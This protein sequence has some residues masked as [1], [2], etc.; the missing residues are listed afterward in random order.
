LQIL[1]SCSDAARVSSR[2]KSLAGKKV[3]LPDAPAYPVGR[4]AGVPIMNHPAHS[5]VSPAPAALPQPA[6]SLRRY[7]A[8]VC[9][10]MVVTNLGQLVSLGDKPLKFLLKD[11]IQL[12]PTA[13]A[14]W[15]SLALI[16][17]S[18]KPLAA[19]F[20]DGLPFRGTR[21][22][23][24][25]LLGSG[26]A[27]CLWLALGMVPKSYHNLLI[28]A[29]TFNI[30]AVL[31]SV[32]VGGLLVE[33]GQTYGAT[34][35]LSSIRMIVAN[36]VL[37]FVGPIGGFL[38]SRWFG[39]TA[40]IGGMLFFSM[41]PA[42]LLLLREKPV[43]KREAG[44][45]PLKGIVRQLKVVFR[46]RNLWI[47]GGLLFLVQLSPGY[48][49]PLFYYQTN[50]LKFS[51]QFIGNLMVAGG[52][53]GLVGSLIYPFLCRRFR[54]RSLLFMSI[55]CTVLTSLCYL[56]YVSH[57]SAIAIEGIGMLGYTLAQLPLFDLAARATPKGSEALGYSVMLA[58]WNISLMISDVLGSYLYD[59][60]QLAF[61]NLVWINAGT[62]ALV[63]FVVP[64]L[65]GYL[66]DKKEG[67]PTG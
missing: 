35:R 54:L 63:L 49:T 53:M 1:Q 13:M 62:T 27:G 21:H 56:G 33:G 4:P 43:A 15:F 40:L 34:G 24:Y 11:G 51:P 17:W 67:E 29:F 12:S 55:S 65:P 52:I 19:L 32:V 14:A 46:S 60:F 41:I 6:M 23:N 5:V 66:V 58:F 8:L 61:R 59:H 39:W 57:K 25:L 20:V 64:F 9:W 22:R 38:A 45:H 42:T 37:L 30:M 36:V 7:S 18:F 26:L 2:T 10:G 44:V 28:I 50:V 31:T 48:N 3:V 16:P 47:C